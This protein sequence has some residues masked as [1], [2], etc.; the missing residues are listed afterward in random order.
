MIK[1]KQDVLKSLQ[2]LRPY[3]PI[4]DA[5]GII[6]KYSMQDVTILTPKKLIKKY[7]LGKS[8]LA[9]TL[10][11]IGSDGRTC[12]PDWDTMVFSSVIEGIYERVDYS[13]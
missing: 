6:D 5:M 3:Q 8:Q 4:K 2:P 10:C 12:V 1:A 11:V 7:Q 9:F 13:K